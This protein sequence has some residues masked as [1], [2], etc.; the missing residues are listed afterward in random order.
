MHKDKNPSNANRK[1]L[2]R[3]LA[4]LMPTAP[5]QTPGT[6]DKG[7]RYLA[8]ERI[9]PNKSQPRK[10][11]DP[12]AIDELAASIE[13]QGILQPIIVRRKGDGY[14]VVAGERRWRAAAKAGLHEI[15]VLVKDFSDQGALEVALIENIQRRDLDPLEEAAAYS[16]LL[17]DHNMTQEKL[18]GSVGKSR[19]T[20]ANS[21]RL[22]K[23][24]K[25][26]L[27]M[28]AEGR[29][30]PGHARALMT[31]NEASQIPHLAQELVKRKATVREAEQRARQ[32]NKEVKTS[33]KETKTPAEKSVE[34]RLQQVL[35][36]RIR[37]VDRKGKGRIEIS[38]HSYEQLDDLLDRIAP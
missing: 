17:K 31:L 4:A 27:S 1:A 20:I 28:L 2:G 24:P 22:L 32:L 19:V 21:L 12:E 8:I 13:A 36:T 23:L 5:T 7:L 6:E 38:F 14:E 35:G 26:V 15:P 25:A 10:V 18:A 29:L 16:R 33:K 3:G 37:L 9:H 11:F 30:S 34:D